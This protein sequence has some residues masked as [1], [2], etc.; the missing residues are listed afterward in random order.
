MPTETLKA[1]EILRDVA[2][3]CPTHGAYSGSRVV[4]GN[5]AAQESRCPNCLEDIAQKFGMAVCDLHGEYD[6]RP[7]DFGMKRRCPECARIADEKR[8][9]EEMEAKEKKAE[10]LRMA[11]IEAN[12]ACSGIPLRYARKTLTNFG[13][14]TDEQ[15]KIL[16]YCEM[17]AARFDEV[18]D[19]GKSLIFSGGPGVGKTHLSCGIAN[20]V[21]KKGH[22]VLYTSVAR[23]VREVRSSWRSSEMSEQGVIDGFC[24]YG[25][26][27]VDEVGVQTGSENE[28]NIL[29]DVL[30]LRYENL[31]PTILLTNLPIMDSADTDG[32]VIKGLQGYIGDR[33]LDRMRENGGRAFA[34][35]GTSYRG[36]N[37]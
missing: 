5:G 9:K 27:I 32:G 25:L 16:A 8:L 17:Y 19:S 26:L 13:P 34:L 18:M 33:L 31:R 36:N 3:L 6:A 37:A 1:P 7:N 35:T 30:N 14:T 10:Q 23:I 2:L 28:H 15:K 4:L 11:K 12:M 21:L 29:F 24:R 22:A 20:D